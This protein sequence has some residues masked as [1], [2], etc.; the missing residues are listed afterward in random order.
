MASFPSRVIAWHHQHGRKDL[1]WQVQDAY[2][3]WVSEIMLQQTQVQTV[4]PYFENFTKSFTNSNRARSTR[5]STT[6]CIIGRA[7]A[8]MHAPATC[9]TQRRSLIRDEHD[10]EFPR[11]L[12]RSVVVIARYRPLDGGGHPVALAFEQAACDPR[13]QREA[14]AG[15]DMAA[16]RWMAG[17]DRRGQLVSGILRKRGRPKRG[18]GRL[19]TQAMMDLGA[20]RYVRAASPACD[21]M[22]PYPTDCDGTAPLVH[23]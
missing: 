11:R 9:T 16:D 23:G 5:P 1:P 4:I 13:W 12:R 10:G 3:V 17:K 20:T 8:T 18:C 7:S 14:R 2:S 6:C 21:A 22:S 19:Y 15:A